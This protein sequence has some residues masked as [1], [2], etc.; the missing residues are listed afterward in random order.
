MTKTITT[1]DKGMGHCQ[2]DAENYNCE[3]RVKA[4]I[5]RENKIPIESVGGRPWPATSTLSERWIKEEE[6][7]DLEERSK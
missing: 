3:C 4:I 1:I 2:G 6:K 7:G 5:A